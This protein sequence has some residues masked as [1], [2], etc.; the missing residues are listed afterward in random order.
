MPAASDDVPYWG[1]VRI[2]RDDVAHQRI[3]T[4]SEI[5]HY[6]QQAFA[7]NRAYAWCWAASL[8]FDRHP[9][10]QDRFRRLPSFARLDADE[11][12]DRFAALLQDDIGVTNEAWQLFAMHVNYGYDVAEEEVAYR[13]T[14]PLPD[15]VNVVSIVANRAWQSSGFD[16]SA[17]NSYHISAKGR[18][19]VR[20][21]P[22]SWPCE[23]GGVTIEYYQGHPV[24]M[25]LAAVSN[26][27]NK[28]GAS[29][30]TR[31]QAVGLGIQLTPH[32]SGTLFFRI[33]EPAGQLSDNSGVVEIKIRHAER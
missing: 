15:G 2:L 7:Q 31:P 17:G 25:L 23:P 33:N 13:E 27:Q 12:T 11:F 21:N 18:F 19:E 28:S 30:L 1:R 9:R 22:V 8:F 20:K 4:I 10:F 6:P 5:M 3:Q 14:R 32:E 26:S 24:G 29:G 16:V